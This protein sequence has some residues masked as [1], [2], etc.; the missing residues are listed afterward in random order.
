[1]QHT[2]C[3]NFIYFANTMQFWYRVRR[4]GNLCVFQRIYRSPFFPRIPIS[5]LSTKLNW[6]TLCSWIGI[7]FCLLRGIGIDLRCLQGGLRFRRMTDNFFFFLV[8]ENWMLVRETDRILFGDL[9]SFLF[10][11][12]INSQSISRPRSTP[13]SIDR[14][15]FAVE[16]FSSL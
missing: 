5:G 12:F 14:L 2:L 13:P 11:R 7:G 10:L 9:A 4:Y 6:P 15:G 16:S 8:A 3:R 1:M